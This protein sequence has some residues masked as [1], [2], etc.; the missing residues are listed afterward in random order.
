MRPEDRATARRQLDKRLNQLWNTDSLMRPPRGWIKAIREALG[1][2]TAQ[3]A[4]RLGVSQPRA[5]TIEKAEKEKSITLATLER[6][7]H[8]LDCRLVYTLVPTTSLDGLVADRARCLAKKRLETT[9]HSMML[10]AQGVD[11]ADEKE[12][13]KRLVKQLIE[14]AGSDLWEDTV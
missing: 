1:M 14:K 2:T 12:Q 9:R 13:F 4:R 7:A 6:A 3:L 5:V 10:E 11:T 8:A